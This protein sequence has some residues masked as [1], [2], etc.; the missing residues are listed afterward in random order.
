MLHNRATARK[1]GKSSFSLISGQ[2]SNCGHLSPLF[3][4]DPLS[5]S[6]LLHPLSLSPHHCPPSL[7]FYSISPPLSLPGCGSLSSNIYEWFL[8]A[9]MEEVVVVL[10]YFSC[11]KSSLLYA[12]ALRAAKPE[13]KIFRHRPGEDRGGSLQI[14]FLNGSAR[15]NSVQADFRLNLL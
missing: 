11:S 15:F 5:Q 6:L 9:L 7:S 2:I 8:A 3:I 12:V 13:G 10:A 4:K 1:A 14:S